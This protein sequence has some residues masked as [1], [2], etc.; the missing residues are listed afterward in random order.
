MFDH[1]KECR[2]AFERT[3]DKKSKVGRFHED[4]FELMTEWPTIKRLIWRMEVAEKTSHEVIK[5]IH[6]LRDRVEELEKLH[7]K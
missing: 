5:E 2:G 1:E 6:G 7:G 4:L 3:E